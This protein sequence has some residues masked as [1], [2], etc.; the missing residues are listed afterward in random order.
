MIKFSKKLNCYLQSFFSVW[1]VRL[2]LSE[3]KLT[4]TEPN[5]FF[6]QDFFENTSNLLIFKV[7]FLFFYHL[8]TRFP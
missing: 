7:M 4:S 2:L 3:L 8:I 5:V 6:Q 1:Y